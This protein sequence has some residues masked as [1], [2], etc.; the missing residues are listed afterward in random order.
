MS[1]IYSWYV[2]VPVVLGVIF[3]KRLNKAQRLIFYIASLSA[4][5]HGVSKIVRDVVVDKNNTWVYHIYVPLLFWLTWRIYRG[6]LKGIFSKELFSIILGASLCFFFINSLFIQGLRVLPT[7][8]I[9]LISGIFIFWGFSY[10]YSL[11]KQTQF[12]SLEKE[13]VFWF[14]TGV[15]MYYSSTVLIFLLVFSYLERNSETSYIVII[16]NVFFNLVLITAYLIS[17]WVKPPQ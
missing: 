14:T 9:F 8:A 7:N 17:I 10:F 11:L 4:V 3:L 16:L 5:N 12:R 6:E 1:S 13:P 2:F 15:I